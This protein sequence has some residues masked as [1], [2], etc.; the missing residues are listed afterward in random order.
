MSIFSLPHS[1]CNKLRSMIVRFLWEGSE[2][3]ICIYWR[4][5][6]LLCKPKYQG[7]M[8]VRDLNAFNKSLLAKQVWRQLIQP[9]SF[10]AKTFKMK[11]F[12]SKNLFQVKTTPNSYFVCQSLL[13]GRDLLFQ[14]VRW[15]VGSWTSIYVFK[16]HWLLRPHSFKPITLLD[17]N[18]SNLKVAD[19]IIISG[20]WDWTK[21]TTIMWE[22]DIEKVN[23]IPLCGISDNEN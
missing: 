10:E 14:E 5:W 7:K 15:W 20:E 1:L 13:W 6:E 12:P 3:V 9:N 11:Y 22:V 2:D 19:F 23:R 16:D 17:N 8:E 4:K 18:L 21:I